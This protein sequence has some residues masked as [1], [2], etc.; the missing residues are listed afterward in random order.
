MPKVGTDFSVPARYLPQMIQAYQ[1]VPMRHVLF[2]HIGDSP[3]HLNM[4]P[5]SPDERERARDWYRRLARRALSLGGTVSAEHGIGKLKRA[6]LAEQV[7]PTVLN[8]FRTIKS[9]LDPNW[10]LGRDTLLTAPD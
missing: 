10:I 6:L 4:L 8:Q 5:S 1:E 7:G 3:L 2:G 9:Q